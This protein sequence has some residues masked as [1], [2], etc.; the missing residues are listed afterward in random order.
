MGYIIGRHPVIRQRQ[1]DLSRN[2]WFQT[3]FQTAHSFT[4]HMFSFIY[5][6]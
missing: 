2:H 1:G 3:A 5:T 6:I 4:K